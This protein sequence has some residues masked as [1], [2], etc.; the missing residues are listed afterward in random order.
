MPDMKSA[1]Q[2][3]LPLTVSEMVAVAQEYGARV[4]DVVLVETE[5]RTGKSREEILT[6][7]MEEYAHNLKAVEI[8]VKDG[9]SILLGTVASQLAAQE[10]EALRQRAA[11]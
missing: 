5:L 1:I 11:G 7:I 6:G 10:A 2:E 3:K 8:S 4:V 9:E